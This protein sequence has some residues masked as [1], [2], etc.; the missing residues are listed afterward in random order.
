MWRNLTFRGVALLGFLLATGSS[1]L[2][3]TPASTYRIE[4]IV[5]DSVTG[6]PLYGAEVSIAP[7]ENLDEEQTFLT[8]GDGRFLFANLPR[9]KYR[10][11]AG[12][13]GYAPQALHQHEGYSTGVA[14]GPGLD[15]EHIRFPL[16]PSSVITGVVT[17]EWGDAVRDA[18][19]LLFQQ[20]MFDGSRTLRNVNQTMT[21]DQ[22][23][24]RFAHLLSGTYAVAVYARPWYTQSQGQYDVFTSE[25]P[26]TI[27]SGSSENVVVDG[28]SQSSIADHNPLFDVVYPATFFPNSTSI[29]EAARLAIA[30]GATETADFQLRAV[31]S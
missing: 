4:G 3:A 22:G 12:R 19:V 21:D 1:N 29:S 27:S 18:K 28:S 13:R 5:V 10:L 8:S 20:S 17:D 15:S 24:Y 7:S 31:P 2:I 6:Q 26:L 23:R 30:P 16:A 11:M 9:G 14:V 25:H